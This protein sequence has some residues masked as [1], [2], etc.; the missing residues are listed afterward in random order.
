MF[1]AGDYVHHVTGGLCLV[2]EITT[3]DMSGVD[4]KKLYYRLKP[5]GETSGT[6]YSPVDNPRTVMRKA[7]GEQEA[8]M[9]IDDM[10]SIETLWIPEERAREQRYKEALMSMD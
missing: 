3:L 9:L 6:L 4:S 10:P 7:V 1:S 5:I 8:R 2:E